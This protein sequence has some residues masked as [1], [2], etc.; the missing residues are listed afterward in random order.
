MWIYRGL[1]RESRVREALE[2]NAALG[3]GTPG[4]DGGTFGSNAVVDLLDKMIATMRIP[5]LPFPR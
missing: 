5:K 3:R 2:L 4:S 1:L